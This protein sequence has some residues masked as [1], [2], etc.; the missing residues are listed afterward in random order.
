MDRR[1]GVN[2]LQFNDHQ[3]LDQQIDPV[4]EVELYAVVEHRKPDLRFGLKPGLL[5][6][7]LKTNL[8]GACEQAGTQFGRLEPKLM[9]GTN[10]TRGSLTFVAF[11]G[12]LRGKGFQA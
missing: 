6:F 7:G 4:T 9:D 10:T 1:D 8:V 5:K 11:L 3:T 12:V 2:R